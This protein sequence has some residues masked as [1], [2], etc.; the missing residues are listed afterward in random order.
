MNEI[1]VE[2]TLQEITVLA[3]AAGMCGHLSNT[4]IQ[5]GAPGMDEQ[6][7]YLAGAA[8]IITRELGDTTH[9]V[10]CALGKRLIRIPG[11]AL[12]LEQFEAHDFTEGG[13]GGSE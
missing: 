13:D 11:D 5:A 1:T 2:L 6:M 3:A 7:R 4:Y 8:G 12:R 9:D 10:L